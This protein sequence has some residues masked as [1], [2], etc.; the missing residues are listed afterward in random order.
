M[1]SNIILRFYQ[2][3]SCSASPQTQTPKGL[4][5]LNSILEGMGYV[6]SGCAIEHIK[7]SGTEEGGAE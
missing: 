6:V 1:K 2:K 3:P 4:E 7:K 5:R